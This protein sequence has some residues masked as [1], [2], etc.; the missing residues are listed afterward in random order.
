MIWLEVRA[1]QQNEQLINRKKIS[2]EPNIFSINVLQDNWPV[3][4][5]WNTIYDCID[6]YLLVELLCIVDKVRQLGSSSAKYTFDN[7]QYR[8]CV[9]NIIISFLPLSTGW[10]EPLALPLRLTVTLCHWI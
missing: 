5:S 4:S 6:M 3:S 1:N 7:I 10:L 8:R 2:F 9:I